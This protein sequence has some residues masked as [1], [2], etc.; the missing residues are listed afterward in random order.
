MYKKDEISYQALA[1]PDRVQM[2]PQS[3]LAAAEAYLTYLCKRH[4]VR[5]YSDRPVSEAV[6]L[7]CIQAAATAPSGE[8]VPEI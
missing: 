2:D 1:L 7:A 4:S 8:V 3:S 6:I 5:Q